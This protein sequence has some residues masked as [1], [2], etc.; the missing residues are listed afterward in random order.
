VVK[1]AFVRLASYSL[2]ME[3]TADMCWKVAPYSWSTADRLAK[4]L[5]LPFVAATILAT[6]GFADPAEARTFLECAATIPDPFLFSDMELAT[7][8]LAQAVERRSR[9]VI[10]GDYDADGITA[11]ALMVLGLRDLGIEAEWYLPSRFTEGFGLSASAVEAI[12]AGGP[13]LLITVDCG[14]NYPDEVA[15]ARRRGLDV[16]VVDHH[17]PGPQ[18]PECALIHPVC[19]NYPHDDLC[20]VGLAFKL[21]HALQ[22]RLTAASLAGVPDALHR[23][24]DLVAVGT[25]ADLAPLRG[26][27]RHYVKEGLRLLTIGSRPGLRALTQVSGCAGS[28]DSGAV[29]FRI[30]PRLNAAGRLADASPPLRLLLTDDEAEAE[31]IAAQL[32]EINGVRQ[33]VERGIFDQAL[34]QIDAL[35]QLPPV[36]VLRSAGW[37]EGVVGIVASRLVERYHRPTILLGERDGIAKGSGRSIA[38]YDMI[39]ALDACAG[40]LTL[41]GGHAQAVGL[42]L[43]A[44]RVDQFRR[45][46]EE[47]AA[48]RLSDDDLKPVYRADAILGPGELDAD[49]AQAIAS[50]GPFG[51]GNPRPHLLLVDATLQQVDVTRVG[52]H[53]RCWVEAAGIKARAI[54][55]GMG[56]R[57]E[58]LR[59]DGSSRVLGVQLRVDTWQGSLRPELV[60]EKIGGSAS[61]YRPPLVCGPDCSMRQRLSTET[62]GGADL[63]ADGSAGVQG[64]ELDY[65]E[66]EVSDLNEH[67]SR[68]TVKPTHLALGGRVYRDMRKGLGRVSALAQ[69]L[70]TG[71]PTMMITC[72]IAQSL[73]EINRRLPLDDLVGDGM[74][75][76]GRA[77]VASEVSR[78]N[79]ATHTIAEW[80][81]VASDLPGG[82]VH[83]IAL[84]PPYREEHATFLRQM[85]GMG[86]R[87]HLLYG[88]E[89]R[90]RTASLLRYLVH[91]RFAMVC[92]YRA[93][94]SAHDW[95]QSHVHHETR[96]VAAELAWREGG[97]MLADEDF[98]R[99]GQILAGLNLGQSGEGKARMKLGDSP[100]YAEAEADYQECSRLCRIL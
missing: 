93:L 30:A 34:A 63:V 76:I 48:D 60:L 71:E 25:I 40:W 78:V 33:E 16:V 13:G 11:T 79:E 19:G 4:E 15:L 84:D 62:S 96:R 29:A 6:R 52:S 54:G 82:F 97:V 50:L 89:E 36:L 27:N 64:G 67:P 23:Y 12:A 28:V 20:G 58:E 7:A 53:L 61:L 92:V 2:A 41:Y 31:A 85:A 51:A 46:M 39:A 8:L 68:P 32:H 26:E 99:A 18:L 95:R 47:H 69:V 66:S 88:D 3:T 77:C 83:I 10:H 37:H 59:D 14:I 56:E 74:R 22:H 80:D 9:V 57:A 100:V 72:S 86:V 42:T 70:V 35:P 1:P 21:L 87:I 90:R 44:V 17:H 65:K 43:E 49:T 45:A 55:F 75:C 98:V 94:G 24:L 91:P 73:E 81:M 38:A 5:R